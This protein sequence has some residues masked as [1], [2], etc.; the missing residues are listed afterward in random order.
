MAIFKNLDGTTKSAFKIGPRGIT[1]SVSATTSAARNDTI[2]KLMADEKIVLTTD[3]TTEQK[4]LTIPSSMVTEVHQNN[5]GSVTMKIREFDSSLNKW[6]D[7][8]DI[9]INVGVGSVKYKGEGVNRGEFVLFGDSG[10]EIINSNLSKTDVLFKE[11]QY[12]ANGKHIPIDNAGNF[13]PTAEAVVNYIGNISDILIE[14]QKGN[15]K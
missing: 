8:I 7:P 13:I 5:D 9:P 15:N 3:A 11:N 6:K 12:D 14:R 2:K 4:V 10:S 1:L